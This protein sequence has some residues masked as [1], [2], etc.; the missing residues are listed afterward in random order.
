MAAIMTANALDRFV[1]APGG[2][3]GAVFLTYTFDALFFEEEVL[4][5]VLKLQEPA[6]A[7]RR[8]LD[9]GRRRLAE[10]P[11]LVIADAGMLRGGQRLPY[12]L[13]RA[14]PERLF[15]PKLALL[16][17]NDCARIMIGSGN[18][19]PGGH[20]DNAELAAVLALDY[21]DD[22]ALLR[23]IGG[24]IETAGARG[25]AW[26]RFLQELRPRLGANADT[27][28]TPPWFLHSYHAT[29][30]LEAFLARLPTDA[31]I[32]RIG[33]LA[34]FHQEDGAPTDGAVFDHLLNA[35][36][37]RST[38]NFTLDV[39]LSWEGNA[40][41]PG[42]DTAQ[43]LD[44]HIGKLWGVADGARGKETVSWFVLGAHIGQH[45]GTYDGRQ[46][47]ERS[48]RELNALRS[49]G[50]LWQ[51][52]P[53]ATFGPETLLD[54]AGARAPLKLWV[55][56]EIHRAEGRV[57]RQPL[58]GKLIAVAITHAGKKQTHIL[59]GSPNASAAALLRV[60]A[61][62]ECALHLVM[63][64]HHHLGQLCPGLVYVPREQVTLQ[65]RSFAAVSPSPARWVEDAVFD[66]RARALSVSWRPGAPRLKLAYP[67]WHH[68]PL[69][70]GVPDNVAT[71][72]PFDLDP[73]CCELEITDPETGISARVPLLIEHIFDLPMAG[74][75]GDLKLE[76]LL[77]LHAGRTT[78]TGIAA[79]RAGAVGGEG[80]SSDGTA[81][82]DASLS[83]REIFRVLL[84]IRDE[85]ESAASLGA[86]RAQ[87]EGTWG[88]CRLA[89]RIV[90][91]PER[92]ELMRAEAWIYAQELA[93]VL[94]GVDF[95]GDPTACD[96]ARLRD[97]AVRWIQQ[98]VAPLHPQTPG[99]AELNR[100]YN[101][102]A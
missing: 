18:L 102:A 97:D 55:F 90:Q 68:R 10:T 28:N 37:G 92:S 81:V 16:L 56:P 71:F 42:T 34:P 48:T 17:Y 63:Q 76:E 20:G 64:G 38:R 54:R 51:T 41:A 13:L 85:L 11:V 57:Y 101:G 98:N 69:F 22:A 26:T 78:P 67:L 25:E 86:F 2:C 72:S 29:P 31:K 12:D 100:F 87:L 27:R 30:L 84:S 95:G 35:A 19:T 77:Q 66:A 82:F 62:V 9:E 74:L 83:P 89:A 58:H 60:G 50:R 40:V 91:A 59:V 88:V 99:V 93:R 7:T 23:E 8:F 15:H 39:G 32:E 75:T 65:E 61:N 70:D 14:R 52:G 43:D 45:F 3:L 1:V 79:R 24:F 73:A 94:R 44:S 47:G 36:Q 96:K 33:V 4:A 49:E 46:T 6:E 5:V 80:A 53:V 21:T